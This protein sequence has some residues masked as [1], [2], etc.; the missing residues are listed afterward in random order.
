MA[1]RQIQSV[2]TLGELDPKLLGRSDFPGYFKGAKK[3]RDIL[4]IPQGGAKRRFGT[5]YIKTLVDTGDSDAPITN[6][7]E[8]NGVEYNFSGS[9]TYLILARPNDRT[10]SPGVSF[11]IYLNN[12]L[13]TTVTS[14]DYT[15]AQIPEL[16]FVPSQSRVIVLHE[17]VQPHELI[18]ASDSSWSIST[19]TFGR[20]PTHDFSIVDSVTYRGASDTFTPSA[21]SGPG[22]TLTGSSAFFDDGHVGGIY[23]GGGGIMRII[24]VNIAGTV[25]TGEV[26]DDFISTAAIKGVDSL[27]E[28]AAWGDY[29]GGT[30]Q[31]L[32][33]GWPSIGIF[34]Q[35]RLFLARTP[36]LPAFIFA[37]D[38]GDYYQFDDSEAL[39]TNAF[40]YKVTDEIVAISSNKALSV[41]TASTVESSSIFLES[42]VTPGNIFITPQSSHGASSL[43]PVILDNQV[44]FVDKNTQQIN[45]LMYD[46][47]TGS[48]NVLNASTFSP[49]V[50][51]NPST[52]AAYSPT[53]N[54]GEILFA[55][56]ADGTMGVLQTLEAQDVQGW[57]LART[58]GHYKKAYASKDSGHFVVERSI[59]TGATVT[60]V[61][62][63]V[64]T[65]NSEFEAITDIT[66]S[67]ASTGTDAAIFTSDGDYV[68]LGHS[69]PF[70]SLAVA[71][72]TV[73][74]EDILPV[75]EYLDTQGNW[76][77]FTPTSDGTSGFTVAGTITWVLS[78]DT[79]NWKAQEFPTTLSD[80][81]I[82]PPLRKFWMRI[83]RTEATVSTTPIEDSLL[84]N[85]GKRL[86]LEYVDFDVYTDSAVSTT[87]DGNGLVTGLDH[88]IGHSVYATIGGIPEGPYF[89]DASG[90]LTVSE[91]S[92][93]VSV[94]INYIPEIVPMPL[95]VEFQYMQS[96]YQPKHIK[97]IYVDYYKSLG[98]LVNGFEIP[99][100]SLDSLVLDRAPIAQTGFY[101][102]TPM[103]GWNP[104][105][106]NTISQELPLPMTIIG[107]GYRLEAS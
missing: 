103:R 21:T 71:L 96:V 107:V 101:E 31:G 100:L 30:P 102:I 48:F 84:I 2:F 104:R 60:G 63:N 54:D 18:R 1:I 72:D 36:L 59:T 41:L 74:T 77:T 6:A 65:A 76:T 29:T 3:L 70:Y 19:I 78:T 56:N 38:S 34:F 28:S 23:T 42:P 99:T 92:S 80:D 16:A 14:T 46:I 17:D 106:I 89:V 52:I 98:I 51:N 82:S 64:F 4:A 27:L 105:Q 11:E 61:I 32:D 13:Q 55:T 37:S 40:S 68:V 87:S 10:G 86:H 7:D 26:L 83:S 57:T 75:F 25:A 62:E 15:I 47:N 95:V 35:N 24:S 45:T 39:D 69:C 33:R 53:S 12:A 20:Y 79:A 5:T 67:A 43:P 90:E 81:V 22:V 9:K 50:I 94:G 93:T 73:S 88:L 58:Q 66:A 49:Q 91:A 8:I 85:V 97:S 44:M